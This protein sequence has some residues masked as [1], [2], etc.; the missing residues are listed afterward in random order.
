MVLRTDTDESKTNPKRRRK[1]RGRIDS[2]PR[3][4]KKQKINQIFLKKV[5]TK[6]GRYAII[7]VVNAASP[8]GKATDSDSVIT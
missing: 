2:L 5:L 6:Q 3:I 7:R 4:L 1:V 8:S